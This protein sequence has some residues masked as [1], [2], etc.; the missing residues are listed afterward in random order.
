MARQL[1][2][3][4]VFSV[5]NEAS[6][7]GVGW[8]VN[9][10]TA[11]TTTRITTYTT[12]SGSVANS[13]PVVAEADGRFPQIWIDTGQSIKWVL[14]DDL[15]V[16]KTTVDDYALAPSPPSISAL[17]YDFLSDPAANPLPVAYGGTG[18]TSAVNAAAA[19]S[20]LPLGGGTLTGQLIQSGAG[21]YLYNADSGQ[22]SGLVAI[23][24]DSDPDPTTLAGQWW[25]QYS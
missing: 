5:I 9:F 16:V 14:T 25:L 19:L 17:L 8:L 15:G 4:G 1:F 12:P 3:I 10:Y 6:A 22:A 7:I 23:T 20:V 13:N 2:D 18:S 24:V 21:A 11:E